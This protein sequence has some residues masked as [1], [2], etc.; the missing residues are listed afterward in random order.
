LT[1]SPLGLRLRLYS[2]EDT[3]TTALQLTMGNPADFEPMPK[4]TTH[5]VAAVQTKSGELR[6][7]REASAE[8]WALLTPLIEVIGPRTPGSAPFSRSRVDGWAKRLAA[9]VG[10]HTIFL[11]RLR[12][13]PN[14][15]AQHRDGPVPVLEAIHAAARRRSVVFV[16]VLQLG[17]VAGTIRQVADSARCD[18]RGVALRVPLLGT[19]AADGRSLSTLVKETLDAVQSDV[20]GSDLLMDLRQIPEDGEI[21]V[22]DLVPMIDDLVAVGQWR[23]VVL[24]GTTMPRTLGGGVVEAGTV[25]RLPRKEWLLWLALRRSRVSR[26]PTYGDY[27]VQHP[28]PPLDIAEGQVPHGIRAAIRYTHDMVTVI[29]RGKEPRRI[30]GREQYRQLCSI[31]VAQPEFAGRDYTWGDRQVA[32]CADGSC[33]PGWEDHWRG[34]GTSHHLRFVVDQLVRLR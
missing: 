7:L 4:G 2:K 9:A 10:S 17:D 6:A 1:L 15:L 27:A 19:V 34:A 11:D 3:V 14:H 18:G 24:L 33:E 29:P 22:D 25:G 32:D 21:D 16:P 26:L 23:S 12:L 5:Y 20:T 31:L 8:T 30:E 13:A 28:E